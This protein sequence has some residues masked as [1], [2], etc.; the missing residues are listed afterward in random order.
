MIS[1]DQMCTKILIVDGNCSRRMKEDSA[2]M[3][4]LRKTTEKEELK[5]PAHVLTTMTKKMLI[6]KR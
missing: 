4:L 6:E 3:Q 2:L 1:M 5:K